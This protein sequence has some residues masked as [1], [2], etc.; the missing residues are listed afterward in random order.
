[1]THFRPAIILTVILLLL[2]SGCRN[3]GGSS[4]LSVEDFRY[5]Q[6][7]SG[8]R[9]VMGTVHNPRDRQIASAQV[10]VSLYDENN[11][12]IDQMQV[13]V[14]NIPASGTKSFKA[15]VDVEADIQGARVR[16]ILVL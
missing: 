4:N 14:Q 10:Q 16:G 8:E 9:Q 2:G 11:V 6:L 15:T 12:R 3:G 5:V 1:M 7:P 13:I